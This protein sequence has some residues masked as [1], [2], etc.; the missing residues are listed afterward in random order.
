[1]QVPLS[2]QGQAET[3][4]PTPPQHPDSASAPQGEEAVMKDKGDCPPVPPQNGTGSQPREGQE[5]WRRVGAMSESWPH[6]VSQCFLHGLPGAEGHAR[7]QP[8]SS[9]QQRPVQTRL[10]LQGPRVLT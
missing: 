2:Q 7:P 6:Q 9:A 8:A 10:L 1:M 5:A 4:T 3:F